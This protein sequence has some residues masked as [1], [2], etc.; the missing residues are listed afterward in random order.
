MLGI[1]KENLCG[2]CDAVILLSLSASTVDT[3][4]SFGGISTHEAEG[5][6]GRLKKREGKR[7]RERRTLACR[8]GEHWHHVREECVLQRGR[9]DHHQL[10]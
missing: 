5:N 8:G 4:C 1:V 7:E 3:G 10:R 2:V 9:Q 6:G